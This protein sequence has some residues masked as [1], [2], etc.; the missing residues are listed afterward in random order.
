MV[1][2]ATSSIVMFPLF[3]F[4]ETIPAAS[5]YRL[6]PKKMQPKFKIGAYRFQVCEGCK[7]E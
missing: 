7:K 6:L 5:A 4:L 2:H 1:K 3:A